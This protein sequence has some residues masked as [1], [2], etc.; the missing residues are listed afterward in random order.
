MRLIFK[1][2][3]SPEAQIVLDALRNAVKKELEKKR[4]LGHYFV[5]WENGKI[6]FTG[7]DKPKN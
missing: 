2:E 1:K 3:I 7:D 6:V 5:T 4:R